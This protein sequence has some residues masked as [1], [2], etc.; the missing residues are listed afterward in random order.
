MHGPL[1]V[2]VD[3]SDA[4]LFGLREA[5]SMAQGTRSA[6]I[7][8]FVRPPAYQ[9]WTALTFCGVC[10][11][12]ARDDVTEMVVEAECIAILGS[13]DLNWR[14]EVRCGEP[15]AALMAAANEYRAETIVVSGR[16]HCAVGSIAHGAI[17]SRL[18]HRW[19]GTLV[20]LHPPPESEPDSS[21]NAEAQR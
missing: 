10:S 14:F 1:V 8:V 21:R 12:G 20:V 15:A 4:S 18:L 17:M 16:R 5:A 11:A 6:L 19:S 13:A 3:G 9:I 2:G 7:A